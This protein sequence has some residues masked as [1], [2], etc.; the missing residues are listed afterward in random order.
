MTRA[1]AAVSL[2]AASLALSAMFVLDRRNV[3]VVAPWP[4]IPM[5]TT[6]VTPATAFSVDQVEEPVPVEIGIAA[7]LGGRI[8]P[9][10]GVSG[11]QGKVARRAGWSR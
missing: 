11:E 3:I 4:A 1:L 5:I 6:P 9:A 2:L 10:P 8:G 7:T